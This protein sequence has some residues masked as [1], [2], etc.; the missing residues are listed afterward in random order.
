MTNDNNA[1]VTAASIIAAITRNMNEIMKVTRTSL[2]IVTEFLISE[3]NSCLN[4][5]LMT[6]ISILVIIN[7]PIKDMQ[8]AVNS[9]IP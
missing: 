1:G 8:I 3:T 7:A 9:N 4:N 2:A 6:F 5:A